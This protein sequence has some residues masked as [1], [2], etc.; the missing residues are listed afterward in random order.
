MGEAEEMH[1]RED[2]MSQA[3]VDKRKY[4]KKHRKEIEKKRKIRMAVKC[5]TAAL[6]IGAII[7]VPMGIKI[8]KEQPKFVGDSTLEAFI[9]N[10]IDENHASDI[11]VLSQS[12]E[13]TEAQN[14]EDAISDA[15]EDA[16][17]K[18]EENN[19]DS[20]EETSE[21]TSEATESPEADK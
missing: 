21:S 16:A 1:N 8:Y 20:I 5:V 19:S 15:I 2:N 4:E 10:Y 7:G 14:A 11:A 13:S 12:T 18:E 9:G 17:K 3:K 6:V